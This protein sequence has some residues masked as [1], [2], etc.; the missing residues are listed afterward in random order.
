MYMHIVHVRGRGALHD[1]QIVVNVPRGPQTK[2]A[3]APRSSE[4]RFTRKTVS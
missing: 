4:L 2:R 1:E 3:E